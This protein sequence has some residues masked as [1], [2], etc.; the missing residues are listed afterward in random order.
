LNSLFVQVNLHGEILVLPS[1]FASKDDKEYKEPREALLH[2]ASCYSQNLKTDLESCDPLNFWTLAIEMLEK[3]A[4]FEVKTRF[5]LPVS[6]GE[7]QQLTQSIPNDLPAAFTFPIASAGQKIPSIPSWCVKRLPNRGEI[8]ERL[9]FRGPVI[10][11]G[12]YKRVFAGVL[13]EGGKTYKVAISVFKRV[14]KQALID[15]ELIGNQAAGCEHLLSNWEVR[16]AKDLFEQISV[17][18]PKNLGECLDFSLLSY[19]RSLEVMQ[20]AAIGL[21]NFQEATKRIYI[22]FKAENIL[23]ERKEDGSFLAAL[24]DHGGSGEPGVNN[25]GTG[26]PLYAPPELFRARRQLEP[27]T[28]AYDAWPFGATLL[29]VV[30]GI[31]LETPNLQDVALKHDLSRLPAW[32]KDV[33]ILKET[34]PKNPVG[35]LIQDCLNALPDKRPLISDLEKRLRER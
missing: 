25:L 1:S 27:I 19:D 16:C 8:K 2:M 14:P 28:P 12:C 4:E 33:D 29:Q 35:A 34:L 18:Y 11:E 32:I 26:T 23:I 7:V 31:N 15:N 13:G 22:D 24:G 10:G 6:D 3:K 5:Q 30:T 21:R 17:L 20:Q 9:L